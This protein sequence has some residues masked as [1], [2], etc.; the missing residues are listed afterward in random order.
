MKILYISNRSNSQNKNGA[1]QVAQRNYEH[2]KEIFN[3]KIE[4]Y[5]IK[6]KSIVSKIIDTFIF[7]RL[8]GIS[9][10]ME[11]EIISILS[12]NEFNYVF[13]ESSSFGYC[14]EKIK[15]K[16]PKIKIITFFH[17][18]NH[19]LWKPLYLETKKNKKNLLNTIKL[20]K[21]MKNSI[22]NEKKVCEISDKIITLNSRDSILLKELYKVSSDKEIGVTFPMRK[23]SRFDKKVEKEKLKLLFVGVGTFLPNIQGIEFFIKKVLPYINVELEI[24][25]KGTEINKEKWESLNSKVKV[26]GTVDSL[27]EYYNDAD[28]VIAPIFMGGGMKVKTAEALSYGKT[29]FGTKEAFEGYEVDYKKVGGL[30][31]TAEEFIK[32]ITEYM[33]WWEN[34][35]KPVFNEYSYQIFKEKYSYES[36]L[37]KF[38][39]I[40]EKLEKEN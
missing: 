19:S 18:I 10:K 33:K 21:F 14:A 38:K 17:D 40:F 20:K 12:T 24:V 2:L 3:R 25:G 36:S 28:V 31:N 7:K 29:I 39:E 23:I 5:L 37:K 22:V 13:F 30:C 6:K 16:Y 26:R 15:K 27:D 11:D 4:I 32:S 34:N 9:I 8:E 35:N 1:Y